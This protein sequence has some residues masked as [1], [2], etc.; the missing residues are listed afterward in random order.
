MG[1]PST[2]QAVSEELARGHRC[3][4]PQG[5]HWV[6]EET[7][8]PVQS[9]TAVNNYILSGA[10]RAS[11]SPIAQSGFLRWKLLLVA[12]ADTGGVTVA[13]E[14]VICLKTT[15]LFTVLMETPCWCRSAFTSEP[16]RCRQQFIVTLMENKAKLNALLSCAHM[17][18]RSRRAKEMCSAAPECTLHTSIPKSEA[19]ILSDLMTKSA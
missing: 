9:D 18:W 3:G 4:W 19:S 8:S 11:S 7:P 5:S 14:F 6:W 15:T 2:C 10:R 13:T 12:G 1:V 16:T 17:R